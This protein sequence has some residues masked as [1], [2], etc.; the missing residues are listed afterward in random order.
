MRVIALEAATVRA[1]V[2][3]LDEASGRAYR[4]AFDAPGSLAERLFV[5]IRELE[6]EAWPASRAELVVAAGGP[7]SFTGL[8]VTAAA[9]KGLAFVT[10]AR[11]KGVSSLAALAAEGP[12]GVL[13][14]A[15]LD[16]RGGDFYYGLYERRG[17]DV[18]TVRPPAV[19]GPEGLA[20][21]GA[22]LFVGPWAAPGPVPGAP[23]REVWPAA[24]VLGRLGAGAVRTSG[25]DDL[26]TFR[27]LY[28][29]RG[30]V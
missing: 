25:P 27:P 17:E 16:A 14:A 21:A 10:G 15:V 7:G 4:R 18:R 12:A 28:L 22:E 8:R 6:R 5:G 19:A 30:Q 24:A 29:K 13:I 9:A 2:A 1:E 11:F 20:A 26:T 23:W 3:F